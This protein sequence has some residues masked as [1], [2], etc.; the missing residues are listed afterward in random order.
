MNERRSTR[1]TMDEMCREMQA[2][3]ASFSPVTDTADVEERAK[4]EHRESKKAKA[5]SAKA[6]QRS[7]ERSVTIVKSKQAERKQTRDIAK[8]E[9]EVLRMEREIAD[10]K[11]R[12]QKDVKKA[13]AATATAA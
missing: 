1:Q 12:K 11:E 3:I 13:E 4:A 8:L 9:A 5:A 2:L 7:A 6:A 10:D